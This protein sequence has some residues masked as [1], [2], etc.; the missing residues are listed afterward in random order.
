[1]TYTVFFLEIYVRLHHLLSSFKPTDSFKS[2]PTPAQLLSLLEL[3]V[4]WISI[5]EVPATHR[6]VPRGFD[7]FPARF[8]VLMWR[9]S[10]REMHQR[11]RQLS[12]SFQAATELTMLTVLELMQKLI[13]KAEHTRTHRA[14]APLTTA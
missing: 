8:P 2:I 14:T 11:T 1:M 9:Q 7:R 10:L 3:D 6:L 5:T 13:T 4:S 12:D